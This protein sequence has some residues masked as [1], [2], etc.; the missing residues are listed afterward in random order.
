M[1]NGIGRILYLVGLILSLAD[2]KVKG[3]PHNLQPGVSVK[4]KIIRHL[5][6]EQNEES[7]LHIDILQS[8]V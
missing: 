5:G 7:V 1:H 2:L 8:N 3:T 6:S 4:Q